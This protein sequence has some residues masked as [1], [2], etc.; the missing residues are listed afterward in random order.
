MVQDESVRAL[1]KSLNDMVDIANKCAEIQAISD[2]VEEMGR[3]C[4]EVASLIHEYTKSSSLSE[5][6][7]VCLQGYH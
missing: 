7:F 2:V 6:S 3:A 4:L 5:T 1:A